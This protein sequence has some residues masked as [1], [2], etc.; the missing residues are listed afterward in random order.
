M[1]SPK[2]R[3]GKPRIPTWVLFAAVAAVLAG[4]GALFVVEGRE[5]EPKQ[6]SRSTD[7][8]GDDKLVLPNRDGGDEATDSRR[9]SEIG[10][11]RTEVD[12]DSDDDSDETDADTALTPLRGTT[13]AL[14]PA[15]AKRATSGDPKQLRRIGTL[16]V[17]CVMPGTTASRSSERALLDELAQRLR[18][19]GARVVRLDDTRGA[20]PCADDRSSAFERADLA[21]V[22]ST[23]GAPAAITAHVVGT[24]SEADATRAQQLTIALGD[25]T[26]VTA[27]LAPE[28][29][30]QKRLLTDHG[31]VDRP[32][33]G[34]VAWLSLGSSSGDVDVKRL[35]SSI[36]LALA[37]TLAPA[38]ASPSAPRSAPK[39]PA[40]TP[41]KPA[42]EQPEPVAPSPSAPDASAEDG[43]STGPEN[44]D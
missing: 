42:P 2:R 40:P 10:R 22:V 15:S 35:A 41:A 32:G 30:S 8:S 19:A 33:G 25:T 44:D 13:V 39:T 16:R 1:S 6:S 29:A 43:G 24:L 34:T 37:R 23:S 5:Q 7:V 27:S 21:L 38:N 28:D 4:S 11:D 31:V 20:V 3:T 12:P 17:P 26:G 9:R 36:A 14:A 18:T